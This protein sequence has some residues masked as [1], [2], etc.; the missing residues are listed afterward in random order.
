MEI[1]RGIQHAYEI[2]SDP[3]ERAWSVYTIMCWVCGYHQAGSFY[4][5]YDKNRDEILFGGLCVFLIQ[6]EFYD[7]IFVV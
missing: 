3:Q 2:L 7:D 5:R 6:F 4:Y 1:F